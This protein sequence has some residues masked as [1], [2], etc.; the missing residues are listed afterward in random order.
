ME[1]V[2]LDPAEYSGKKFTVRYQTN[3]YYD[4]CR[5]ESGFRIEYRTFG[6]TVEKSFDDVFF[7]RWLE[8]PVGYGAFEGG[9]MAGYVEG[10][11]ETWNN[12]YRISNLFVSDAGERRKGIGTK[13]MET[14]L[15]EAR[16]R[17]ARMAVLETQTC[18]ERAIAFYRKN[19]FRI[20]GFDLYAYSNE[21][22]ER[23]EVRIELGRVT[24][25]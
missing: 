17:G 6:K 2:K 3:G 12:R 1:I 16:E 20:I 4:I 18:N 9:R 24:A 19:G 8:D 21:D 14:I 23:Y 10:T 5:E 13:L 25:I 11:P 15:R 22:P 7:N